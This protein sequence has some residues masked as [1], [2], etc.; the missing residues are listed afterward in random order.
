MIGRTRLLNTLHSV[1]KLSKADQT[2]VSA[3]SVSRRIMRFAFE[4]IH[5]DL[6]QEDLDLYIKVVVDGRV[7]VACANSLQL[8]T[9]KHA[10]RAA[11]EIARHSPKHQGSLVLPKPHPVPS[12]TTHFPETARLAPVE[13]VE[14][15]QSLFHLAKGCG[16]QLAGS[17]L[18]GEE[19]FAVATSSGIR[20]Y[21]PMTVAALKL[22]A[23]GPTVSGFA[24]SVSRNVRDLD[25]ELTLERALKKCLTRERPADLPLGAYTVLLEPEAVG[26]L[27][28]WLGF[29]AFGA[30]A[31]HERTSFLAGRMGERLMGRNITITDDGTDPAGLPMPFDFE[32]VARQ[33]VTLI[34]RGIARGLV[35]D[36]HYARL[37]DAASTGHAQPPDDVEGPQPSHLGIA[38]GATPMEQLLGRI[39][40]GILVTRF[41]YVNGLLN[42]R[43]ALMTGLTRDG[44]FLI[45]RGRLS[46]PLPNLRFTQSI[47]EALNQVE[48]ISRERR[49]VADPTQEFGAVLAPALLLRRFTFTGKSKE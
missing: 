31:V 11:Q 38:A 28:T 40:R 26:E 48:A 5:Q 29:L 49:L 13:R 35:Y 46:A 17:F 16:A 24:S 6:A 4:K 42:P 15:I 32:G 3:W 2:V 34:D 20:R 1:V 37:F 10:L 7:G 41:H 27:L 36:T 23:I 18:S 25:M 39:D 22:V 9:L 45:E 33:P 44:T 30:K 21:Q 12:V 14:R 8:S 19:E 43:E 47:L